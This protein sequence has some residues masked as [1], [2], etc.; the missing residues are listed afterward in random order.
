MSKCAN[1][2]KKLTCGC[3]RAKAVNGTAACTSCVG[4]LNNKLKTKISKDD[5]APTNVTATY[6]GP[7]Q[8]V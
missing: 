6:S 8:Q 5:N 7:G 3:Q 1:C 4:A 2:G